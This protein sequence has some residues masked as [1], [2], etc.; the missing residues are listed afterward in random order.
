MTV[1][2]ECYIPCYQK[3][4]SILTQ[5]NSISSVYDFFHKKKHED[6]Q[7]YSCTREWEENSNFVIYI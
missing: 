1:F 7:K 6:V 3:E 4:Q 2:F 5:Y